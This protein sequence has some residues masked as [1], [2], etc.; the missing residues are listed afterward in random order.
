MT[1]LHPVLMR[2]WRW[3]CEGAE[4]RRSRRE[5]PF[6]KVG[7]N[8]QRES[9]PPLWR[10]LKSAAGETPSRPGTGQRRVVHWLQTLALSSALVVLKCAAAAGQAPERVTPFSETPLHLERQVEI[11]GTEQGDAELTAPRSILTDSSY[12]YVLDSAAF[13]VHR[14][15]RHGRWETTIGKEGE[16]PGEFRRPMAMGWLGDTLWVADRGLS[17]LSF[18]S[19]DG[20]FLRSLRFSIISGPAVV[21][22]R[23]ALQGARVVSVPY[24][25]TRSTLAIDSLPVLL[26]DEE[27]A[28]RDTL[29][30]QALG[31]VAVVV[32]TSSGVGDSGDRTLSISHPFDRRSLLTYDPLSRWLDLGTWRP[33]EESSFELLRITAEADTIVSV[34]LPLGRVAMPERALRRLGLPRFSGQVKVVVSSFLATSRERRAVAA[35]KAWR[36]VGEGRGPG[37]TP[38]PLSRA[39]RSWRA[40]RS[41]GSSAAGADCTS[42]R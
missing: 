16:G 22:P 36:T 30:W 4:L 29:A 26:L 33:A 41:R 39:P 27:G 12:I 11:R 6:V 2:R 15:D 31:Q 1:K 14:F 20:V 38:P 13:G 8:A 7:R 17:R 10:A 40:T 24:V 34:R 9:R 3:L 35:P 5:N 28:I 32:A 23:R 37:V 25:P 42:P 18:F 19:P 21:M